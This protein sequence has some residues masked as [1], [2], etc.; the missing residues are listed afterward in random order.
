[1][2]STILI[3]GLVPQFILP[4]NIEKKQTATYASKQV[5]KCVYIPLTGFFKGKGG[6]S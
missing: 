4:A 3:Y 5:T 1:M 6:Y 2:K